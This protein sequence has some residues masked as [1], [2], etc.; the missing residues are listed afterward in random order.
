L[1]DLSN[2]GVLFDTG[3]SIN[4]VEGFTTS[5]FLA[6]LDARG[7]LHAAIADMR[8][9][10]HV[11]APSPQ[12]LFGADFLVIDANASHEKMLEAA[13]LAVHL[14]VSVFF[15]PTSVPKAKEA[16]KSHDF[17]S[18][19]S[20]ASPNAEEL[21]AMAYASE[22]IPHQCDRLITHNSKFIHDAA[23]IVLKRMMPRSFLIVTLGPNGVLLASK[24][25]SETPVD[26]KIIFTHF[27][28]VEIAHQQ[29]MNTTGGGDSFVGAFLKAIIDGKDHSEAIS[30][31]Q[32]IAVQCISYQ[33]SAISPFII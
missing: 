19:L 1:K 28:A 26:D 22:E 29:V 23:A 32:K 16:C 2:C 14:G 17:V 20:Y 18:C 24:G 13:Q 8:V 21:I 5:T 12:V 11:P 7:D 9:L 31:G 33:E 6:M 10:V 15:E 30:Y 3:H 27:H 4:V 25:S